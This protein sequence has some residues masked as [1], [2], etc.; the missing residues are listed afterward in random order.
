MSTTREDIPFADF[1]VPEILISGI[2]RIDD[3]GGG[4]QRYI[5]YSVHYTSD[6]SPEH[7][8]TVDLIIAAEHVPGCIQQALASL[9]VHGIKMLVRPPAMIQH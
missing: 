1:N 7:R 4:I 9:V 5:L 8:R 6:G 2:H 3:L